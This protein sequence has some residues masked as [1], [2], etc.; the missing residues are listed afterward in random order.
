MCADAELLALLLDA[1][2]SRR[3]DEAH[4]LALELG[5]RLGVEPAPRNIVG[6]AGDV[7]AGYSA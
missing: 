5:R 2:E 4:E 3:S 1:I 7:P 6:E